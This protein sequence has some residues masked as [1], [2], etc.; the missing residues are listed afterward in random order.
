MLHEIGAG[1]ADKHARPTLLGARERA[2]LHAIARA[3]MPEGRFFAGGGTR[4]VDKVDTFLA[5][6]PPSV[7]RG[8]R[9]MLLALDAWA[10]ATHRAP[11][12]SLPAETVLALL[13]RWRTGDIARRTMVRMLTAPLKIAHYND[14]KMYRDVGCRYGSLPVR[15]ERPRWM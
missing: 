11:L 8:Y 9:A 14:P 4:A 15:A 6:S 2:A 3:S 5:L 7:G 1:P 10:M 12:A 13:E